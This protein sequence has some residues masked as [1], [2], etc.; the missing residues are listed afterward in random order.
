[1]AEALYP[2]IEPY[3]S[4]RLAVGHGH[5]LYCEQSGNPAGTPILFLH[6]G[7]GSGA[8]AVHRRFFDPAHYRIVIF[9]Q[10]GAGRSIPRASVVEN[11]T[12]RLVEDIEALRIR[13]GIERW[14]VFG[15]SWGSTLAL[16]YGETHPERCAGFILRGIFLGSDAELDWFL[17]GLRRIFPEPWQRFAQFLPAEERDDLLTHYYR[18]LVDPDPEIHRPAAGAWAS[19][20]SACSTL[21]P[22]GPSGTGS[23]D[24][25]FSLAL[26][27]I[28]AHYM[29]HRMFLRPGQ[30]IDD[31]VRIR[32][33]PAVM[34][35]GR[36]DV[37]CPCEAAHRLHLSWP[38]SE[39]R[40]IADAGHS[41]MEPGTRAALVGA[42]DKM[43]SLTV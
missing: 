7:P 36:Y 1:V 18:R 33:L 19:Y 22:S 31:L 29:A 26:A 23:G 16:A 4:G 41:A 39:L 12:Q 20:E 5:E 43:R 32:E 3:E 14:I 27:R 11:T 6:G 28:E 38:G 10:R 24:D 30:L 25:R 15:G 37:I 2:S 9:D 21:L 35:Q 34:V 8:S 40:I 42:A 17:Y 13:L